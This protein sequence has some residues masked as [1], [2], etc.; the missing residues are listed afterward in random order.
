MK[1]QKLITATFK[2][3]K[4]VVYT[5]AFFYLLKT[6]PSVVE[7]VDNETGEILFCR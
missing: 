6:D 1:K 5:M 3:H 7:I 2:S 4:P